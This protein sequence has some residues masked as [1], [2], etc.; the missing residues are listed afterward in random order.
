MTK[1]ICTGEAESDKLQ[2]T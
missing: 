1:Y 2:L